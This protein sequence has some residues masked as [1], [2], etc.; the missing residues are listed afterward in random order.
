[1]S[2]LLNFLFLQL[3][4]PVRVIP[5]KRSHDKEANNLAD[6]KEDIKKIN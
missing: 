1:M 4:S 6:I 2:E 3:P 5:E